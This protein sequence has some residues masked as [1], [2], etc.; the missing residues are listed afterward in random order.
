MGLAALFWEI[1]DRVRNDLPVICVSP[2]VANT[3]CE[4]SLCILAYPVRVGTHRHASLHRRLTGKV[5]KRI[6][7]AVA[8]KV[9]NKHS[10]TV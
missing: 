5:G 10:Q 8:G 2:E 4:H 1:P 3:K 6:L 7:Q 9:H